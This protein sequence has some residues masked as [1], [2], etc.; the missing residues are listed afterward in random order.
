[1][2]TPQE[3]EQDISSDPNQEEWTHQLTFHSTKLTEPIKPDDPEF[4]E[5]VDKFIELGSKVVMS[6]STAWWAICELMDYMK[7]RAA[8]KERQEESCSDNDTYK[9]DDNDDGFQFN[10]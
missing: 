5:S 6:V 9:G 10:S 8:E 3:R 2:L 1:M 7:L 4:V